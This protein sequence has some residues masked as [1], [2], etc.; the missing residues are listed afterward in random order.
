[1]SDELTLQM[2]TGDELEEMSNALNISITGLNSK[3]RFAKDIGEGTYDSELELLSDRDALGQS[4][5]QMR[6]NLQRASEEE[7]ARRLEAERAA[8]ASAG[9][10]RF[11]ELLRL[12]N[13]NL[14]KLSDGVVDMLE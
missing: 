14:Q 2:N 6:D 5:I 9:L 10:A 1:M 11:G 4:L 7:S 3:A 12:Y 8:W 13:D